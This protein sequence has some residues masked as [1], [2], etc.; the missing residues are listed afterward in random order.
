MKPF[1]SQDRRNIYIIYSKKTEYSFSIYFACP[2]NIL[3][4]KKNLVET[5][6]QPAMAVAMVSQLCPTT[7][8]KGDTLQHIGIGKVRVYAT[9]RL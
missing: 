8:S 5:F 3:S 6:W 1:R 4:L 2:H 9:V 7:R